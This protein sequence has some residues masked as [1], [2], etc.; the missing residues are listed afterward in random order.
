MAVLFLVF[1]L[2]LLPLLYFFMFDVHFICKALFLVKIMCL[3][4]TFMKL[5]TVFLLTF[6][7]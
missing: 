3:K 7:V 5:S 1:Y 4:Q 2:L 6:L